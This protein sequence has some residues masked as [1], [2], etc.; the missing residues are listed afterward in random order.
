[1][2]LLNYTN[3]PYQMV[4]D[5]IKVID[6]QNAIGVMHLGEFP[7]GIVF[8]T[9]VMARQNYPF[10]NMS[11]PDADALFKDSRATAPTSNDVEGEWEGRAIALRTPDT[12]LANQVAPVLFHAKFQGGAAKCAASG[13]QF[14]RAFDASGLRKLAPDTLLGRW[15]ALDSPISAVLGDP[16]YFVLSR[17]R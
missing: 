17:R 14:T 12:S 1:V 5:T 16:L 15:T 13:L 10:T 9:F 6:E 4:Y 3:A 8:A 7:N 2:L 11:V